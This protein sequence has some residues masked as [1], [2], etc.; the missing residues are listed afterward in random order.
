MNKKQ[1]AEF[2]RR[3]TSDVRDELLRKIKSGDIPDDWDGHELRQLLS[4][5]FAAEVFDRVMGDKRGK[6]RKEY[7]RICAVNNL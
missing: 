5:K 6:R 2:V 3:I 7:E 1:K 4:D